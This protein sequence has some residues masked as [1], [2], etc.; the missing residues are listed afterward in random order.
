MSDLK[1]KR[2]KLLEKAAGERKGGQMREDKF[3]SCSCAGGGGGGEDG[4]AAAPVDKDTENE[5]RKS[6]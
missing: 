1:A 5:A 3:G 2:K 6:G 4:V